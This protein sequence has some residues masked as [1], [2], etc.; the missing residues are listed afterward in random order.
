MSTEPAEI[1]ALPIEERALIAFQ[2]AVREAIEEHAR[3][4]LPMHV[5]RDGKVVAVPAEEL[6]DKS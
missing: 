3:E 2:V 1:L 6:L 4:G 5:W